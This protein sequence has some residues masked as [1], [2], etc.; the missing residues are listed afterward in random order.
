M[1]ILRR[2]SWWCLLLV[3][4]LSG[5]R[6]AAASREE[7]TFL[8]ANADFQAR[9]WG[10]AERDFDQF[11]RNYRHST[12]LPLAVLL[13][14]QA[15]YQQQ[16]YPAVITLLSAHQAG[17]GPLADQYQE[18]IAESHF[19]AS[20]YPAA[21]AA[22]RA[23]ARNYPASP[24]A[25]SAEV[26]SAAAYEKLG[27][28]AALSTLLGDTNSLFVKKAAVDAANEL[29]QRGRLLLAQAG[30][31]QND[32]G[33]AAAQLAAIDPSTLKPG[34][35]WQYHYLLCR[36][37]L[38]AGELDAALSVAATLNQIAQLKK[39]DAWRAESVSLQAEVLEKL[40]RVEEAINAYRLNLA[41]GVPEVRQGEAIWKIAALSAWLGHFSEAEAILGRFLDQF[42]GSAQVPIAQLS[43][44]ELQLKEFLA[45]GNT[46]Q[47]AAAAES[48]NALLRKYPEGGLAGKATLDRGWCQWLAG[49]LPAAWEDFN[50]ARQSRLAPTE[51]A[52]AQF[53]VGD[54]L[55]AQKDYAGALTN[56]RAILADP[57]ATEWQERAAYQSLRCNLALA[58]TNG[59]AAD[60]A[61]I[62]GQ[63]VHGTFT[64]GSVLL[65][66]ESLGQ[67]AEARALF[68]RLLPQLAGDRLTPE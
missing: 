38:A 8:A 29:V 36:V 66:G 24:A 16:K 25:L 48:F 47:L 5:S 2:C 33:A 32:Y 44:G 51:R 40:G 60:F 1:V 22:Y 28:W 34:L 59:A 13:K 56:Y 23:L 15:Q 50:R 4:V 42:P 63:F 49:N 39:D 11:I 30:Y 55:L 18:W 61:R 14:A 58:N 46:N 65:Y 53:K 27:D 45:Q 20:N 67:P 17:A 41:A 68:T 9:M 35:D 64:P 10:Q 54:V 57:A 37:R 7:R 19:A 31:E 62:A 12:N 6:L 3:L 21:A 43:V 26:R 52:L